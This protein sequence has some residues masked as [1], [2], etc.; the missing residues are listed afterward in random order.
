MLQA[1]EPKDAKGNPQ[2]VH[3]IAGVGRGYFWT[4]YFQ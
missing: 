2:L 3:Y 1:T 4:W